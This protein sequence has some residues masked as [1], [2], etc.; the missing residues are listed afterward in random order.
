MR[1]LF[2]LFWALACVALLAA[3]CGSD[4]GSTN[5]GNDTGPD[6]GGD[7]TPDGEGDMTPDMVPDTTPDTSDATPD[8]QPDIP[9]GPEVC[10]PSDCTDPQACV[11]G[12]CVD[13]V[14]DIAGYADEA[15]ARPSS[16]FWSIQLPALYP[17][18]ER[19]CFDYNGDPSG[20]ADDGL[21]SLLGLVGSIPGAGDF[22]IQGTLD[23]SIEDG[24]ITL[25]TDWRELPDTAGDVKFSILLG[26]ND[27]NND[28]ELDDPFAD[29]DGLCTAGTRCG[30]DGVFALDPVSFGDYGS[31]VQFNV[32]S[33]DSGT[34]T[35]GP[36]TFQLTISIEALGSEP[37]L[38]TLLDAKIE[39]DITVDSNGVHTVDTVQ[40]PDTE[41]EYFQA[42][43][44]LGGVIDAEEILTVL[45]DQF[46]GC[47]CANVDPEQPVLSWELDEQAGALVVSCTDNTGDATNE[48]TGSGDGDGPLCGQITTVCGFA[49]FIG[50]VLDVDRNND[51]INES[52]SAG[53][54]FAWTGAGIDGLIPTE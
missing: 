54:R 52:L 26:T 18:P 35:A 24:T 41:D 48:C 7:M 20:N 10:E 2:V 27:V 8:V 32:G 17:V 23:A 30:G 9:V 45:D 4:S 13:P 29:N 22:D 34:V 15:A 36:S 1:R 50:N 44:K 6:A 28:G 49:G 51:G 25:I 21:G 5:G 40:N 11:G 47:T 43:G 39:A 33:L 31:Q 19:C 38:L 16:Y 42:G 12:A 53:L 37:L 3:G 14:P 46:R